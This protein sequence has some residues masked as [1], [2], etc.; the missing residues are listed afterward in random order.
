[1]HRERRVLGA[2]G[3]AEQRVP[4]LARR[5]QLEPDHIKA[6]QAIQHRDQL[7]RLAHLLTQRVGLGVG[8][9]HLG[10]GVPFGNLQG[11]AQGDMQ[12][13]GLL[14]TRRASLAGS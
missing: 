13:Q 6:P 2:L 9:L 12:G 8:V 5:V 14:G 1:M 10:R 7:G 11:R 4:E 3:Q